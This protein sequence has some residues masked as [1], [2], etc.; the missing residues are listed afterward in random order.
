MGGLTVL[1]YQVAFHTPI[2]RLPAGS[3]NPGASRLPDFGVDVPES[4]GSL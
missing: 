1:Q 2:R 3:G 4:V